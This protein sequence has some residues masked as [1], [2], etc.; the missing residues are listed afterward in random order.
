M[1]LLRRIAAPSE[2][3][4]SYAT[5]DTSP[6]EYALVSVSG[7]PV[8]RV[9]REVGEIIV[10]LDGT[11]NQEEIAR[12]SAVSQ[13][14]LAELLTR[15]DRIGVLR[16]A[17][18]PSV[19]MLRAPMTI[20]VGSRRA[21]WLM[22]QWGWIAVALSPRPMQLA[23]VLLVLCG[24]LGLARVTDVV[25]QTVVTAQPLSVALAALAGLVGATFLHEAAHGAV[26]AKYGATPARAGVM[27]MMLAPAFFV[28]VT[29]G[30]SLPLRRH[31]VEVALAGPTTHLLLA[32]VAFSVAPLTTGGPQHALVL[33]GVLAAGVAAFNLIPFVRFDGYLALMA[34]LD[35]PHLRRQSMLDAASWFTRPI[36]GS[37]RTPQ[38]D[39]WW[40]VPFGILSALAPLILTVLALVRMGS[41]LSR[42]GLLGALTLVSIAA[43]I[44]LV[45]IRGASR[46]TRYLLEGGARPG[47][48]LF[49]GLATVLGVA[50]IVTSVSVP[51]ARTGGFV[52]RGAT[53][54]YVENSAS[55][56][57]SIRPG[58]RV[59]L[60]TSGLLP[61][62]L[63]LAT[64][65]GVA[66]RV[67]SVPL[68]AFSPVSAP[69]VAVVARGVPLDIDPAAVGGL[70]AVGGARVT[71][72]HQTMIQAAIGTISDMVAGAVGPHP[73]RC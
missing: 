44:V 36:T 18:R 65:T 66:D 7:V 23:G 25:G 64:A 48:V 70:P 72:G 14:E 22:G 50:T 16:P 37:I 45:I 63:G 49:L 52:V 34:A 58:S 31:R 60:H 54:L 30:W 9:S 19:L 21:G 12:D 67:V 15:L 57:L 73:A 42:V 26:L 46:A 8:A 51:I 2:F 61:V 53:V 3:P 32:S 27:V 6:R 4:T 13:A 59:D 28:D 35:I 68:E 43:V 62:S 29:P 11:R 10:R 1:A 69:G 40:S 17:R 55:G 20:L 24:V 71:T 56:C 41:A 5:V 47:R 33:F 38:I 39:R